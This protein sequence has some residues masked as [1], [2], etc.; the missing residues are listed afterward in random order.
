VDNGPQYPVGFQV[1]VF[2]DDHLVTIT[3]QITGCSDTF[4]ISISQPPPIF[5]RFDNILDSI[6]VP[7]I[8]VGLGT[9]VRLNPIISSALPIDS[10]LWTPKDYLTLGTEPL[11]PTV[12]P[13]DDRTYKLK[14]ID[15]NGC[16]GEAE[17]LV[18][19]E[20]NRNVFVP[21]VFSPNSDDKNDYFSVFSGPGVKKINFVRV[22]D[23]WGE[24]L[25]TA[26]NLP[27]SSDPSTGWD[28]TFRGK[29]VGVGV[30]VFLVE[31]EFDDGAKLLYRGDVTVAR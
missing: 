22:F 4:S 16:I 8:L 15:V 25:Y 1:P 30:Y 26:E 9:D 11:R 27:P 13:L 28:G 31:A 21:N 3:E 19:L 6:P 24:L 17:I 14:V 2:A 20:R 18:E 23:R 7:R 29:P 5:I 12:R 10:V